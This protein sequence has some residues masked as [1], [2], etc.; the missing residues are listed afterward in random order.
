MLKRATTVDSPLGFDV[1]LVGVFLGLVEAKTDASPVVLNLRAPAFRAFVPTD[2]EQSGR[3]VVSARPSLVF[4]VGARRRLTQVLNPVIHRV[5]I[6]VVKHS[7][8]PGAV[9][10]QPSQPMGMVS[11]SIQAD[12]P[13]SA[14]YRTRNGPGRPSVALNFS[15][16]LTGL[17]VVA[18]DFVKLFRVD[19]LHVFFG[20]VPVVN[21]KPS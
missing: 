21:Y 19:V 17:W 11:P 4:G 20:C 2:A 9:L 13:V 16:K 8:G 10:M 5:A 12:N 7:F 1:S 18:K 3:L 15:R 14:G 6:D